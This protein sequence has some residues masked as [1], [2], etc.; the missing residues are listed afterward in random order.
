MFFGCIIVYFL[1]LYYNNGMKDELNTAPEKGLLVETLVGQRLRLLRTRQ[2]FSLRALADRSGLNVNTLSLIENGKS[3][4]SVG[5]L[6]Q[7]ALALD[8]PISAFFESEPL[9]KRVVFTRANERPQTMIGST[10]M[11]NL[12]NN[13]VQ[14][15]VQPFVVTLEPGKG[16]GDRMIV[17][18]GREFVFGLSGQ[19]R[20]SIDRENY[21][22]LPGDSLLFEAHLPHCWENA[23]GEKAQILLVLYPSDGSEEPG[24]RHFSLEYMKKEL[25]MKIAVITDDGQTI[26]RH[27]GR[28]AY[29]M[30]VTIDEGRMTHREMRHKM[31]HQQ[32]N[33]QSEHQHEHEHGHEHGCGAES[34][35]KH[36]SMAEAIS[37]CKALLCGGM[38]MGA[39]ES[40]RRLNI[41]P[42]VTELQNIDEAVQAFIDG[43]LVDHTEW[44]H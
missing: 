29:Y 37:D 1:I 42:V 10:C 3:S 35:N 25:T 6:Q 21:I 28:A 17:H 31:G 14:N 36:V 32:F 24:G 13:F 9:T 23:G 5:T 33:S 19:V 22:V 18:T 12:G 27:F 16:S 7:L 4:P 11:Q 26:S 38:G 39:Y 44:L 30:V 34:H 20:Y 8:V 41:Q 43:R 40:M 2:G 15:A